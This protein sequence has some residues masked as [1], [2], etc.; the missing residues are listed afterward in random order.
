VDARHREG[1]WRTYQPPLITPITMRPTWI[2]LG[3]FIRSLII[4]LFLGQ[5]TG[6]RVVSPRV[7]VGDPDTI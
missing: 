7:K 5:A 3:I 6:S 4:N 2:S 1:S